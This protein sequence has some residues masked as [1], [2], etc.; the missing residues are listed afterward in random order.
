MRLLKLRRIHERLNQCW[1]LIM[2]RVFALAPPEKSAWTG[3]HLDSP[4][5]RP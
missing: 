2:P 5:A 3:P 4:V 1:F